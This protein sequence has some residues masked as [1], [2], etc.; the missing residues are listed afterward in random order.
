RANHRDVP[1]GP[2]CVARRVEA[3]CLIVPRHVLSL[4][5]ALLADVEHIA[6]VSKPNECAC[7][8]SSA[9]VAAGPKS[10]HNSPEE[11]GSVRCVTAGARASGRESWFPCT[12]PFAR[13]FA[14]ERMRARTDRE[15]PCGTA[16]GNSRA[17]RRNGA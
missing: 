13:R 9:G 4:V 14:A 3:R 7:G 1:G 15:G 11:G 5:R 17:P 6:P 16:N 12:C 10:Y 2:R 8:R